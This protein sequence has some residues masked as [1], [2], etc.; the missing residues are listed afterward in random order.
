[1][2]LGYTLLYTGEFAQAREHFE[3]GITLYDPEQH[4]SLAFI[5]LGIDPGEGC[6]VNASFALFFL[7][8]PDQALKRMNEALV[9]SRKLSHRFTLAHA[10]LYASSLHSS[11]GEVQLAQEA[12]KG[13][14]EISADQGFAFLLA[15]GTIW[16]G[17]LLAA[18]GQGEE[19]IAQIRQGLTAFRATGAGIALPVYLSFLATAHTVV[20]Q[21]EEGLSVV[22]EALEVVQRTGE[23]QNEALLYRLKGDLILQ[24]AEANLQA[25]NLQA[26]AEACFQ[27]ALDVARHQSAKSLELGAA[28]S[29]ARLWQ[30]QGK[31]VEAR[32]LLA[33]VYN[34]FTEGFDT[35]DLQEAKALLA[36][37][38]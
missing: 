35:K 14:I 29:L 4:H 7:G 22:A 24:K 21:V 28:M 18:Q 11:L 5:Y 12:V 16:Q 1:M 23:R 25:S 19:G 17:Y 26:E 32:N 38:Q 13:L 36:E 8:Y 27:K 15:Q 20:E 10:L 33:P 30:E 9:L 6:L 37:L 2:A 3:Q 34:W 31:T